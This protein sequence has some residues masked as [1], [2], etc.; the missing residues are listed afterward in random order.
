MFGASPLPQLVFHTKVDST[1]AS[2][3]SH[4]I[5][6]DISLGKWNQTNSVLTQS[7]N[8]EVLDITLERVSHMHFKT[9]VK[10]FFAQF[11]SKQIYLLKTSWGSCSLIEVVYPAISI[12]YVLW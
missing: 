3:I 10:P 7:K 1:E 11:H 8:I 2:Q 9:E 12:S 5:P 4:H 6:E